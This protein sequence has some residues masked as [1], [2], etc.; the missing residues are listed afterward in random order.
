[1]KKFSK[2]TDTVNID[3]K[4]V[5]VTSFGYDARGLGIEI[6]HNRDKALFSTANEMADIIAEA[7]NAA[8][9]SGRL[10]MPK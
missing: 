10:V 1:M 5:G 6:K 4:S 3:N 8:I 7:L 2:N 9:A